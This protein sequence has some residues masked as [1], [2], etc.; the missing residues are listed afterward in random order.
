MNKKYE[1]TGTSRE[2]NGVKCFQIRALRG[3]GNV[4]KG[5]LGGWIERESNLSHEGEAWI[6]VDAWV[7]G[8]A[9]VAGWVEKQNKFSHNGIAWVGCKNTMK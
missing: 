8:R 9:L 5:E 6:A 3:F 1:L 2:T 7:C 4:K